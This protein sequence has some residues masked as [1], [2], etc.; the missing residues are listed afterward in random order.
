MFGDY[1]YFLANHTHKLS[2]SYSLY[3]VVYTIYAEIV[4]QKENQSITEKLGGKMNHEQIWQWSYTQLFLFEVGV[5]ENYNTFK[6][7][8]YEKCQSNR[9]PHDATW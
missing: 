2:L 5:V 7:V 6:Q 4:W 9:T 3:T 1:I 8:Q